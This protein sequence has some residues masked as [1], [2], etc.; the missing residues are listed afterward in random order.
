MTAAHCVDGGT[1]GTAIFGGHFWRT[2]SEQNQRRIQFTGAHIL[3]HPN[4]NP[5]LVQG[6]VA[7]VQL[8]TVV[9]T[10]PGVIRAAIL[11]SLSDVN[12]DF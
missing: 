8:P 9:P 7:V 10:I 1:A 3:L 5:Q 11:P 6:D 4:W 12:Y 2:E